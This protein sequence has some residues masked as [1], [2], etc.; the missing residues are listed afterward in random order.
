[1]NGL[2]V[3]VKDPFSLAE[4]MEELILDSDK[5]IR[6]GMEG[7]KIAEKEFSI[8]N[9]VNQTLEIYKK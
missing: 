5:R 4:A 8:Q 6:F 2:L 1:M 7:R 9:V 3:K